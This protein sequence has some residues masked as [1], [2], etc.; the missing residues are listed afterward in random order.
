MPPT[1][2]PLGHRVEIVRAQRG[3]SRDELARRLKLDRSTPV[4]WATTGQ[5]PRDLEAVARALGVEVA[6]IYA[7]RGRVQP[8]KRGR[9]S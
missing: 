8:L 6:A 9:Q 4:K 7:A 5:G 1:Q 2:I 3:V